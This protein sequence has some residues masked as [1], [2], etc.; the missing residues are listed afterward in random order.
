MLHK[1]M[2]RERDLILNSLMKIHSKS[3]VI[4]TFKSS[5]C[6]TGTEK[7]HALL[8]SCNNI[9]QITDSLHKRTRGWCGFDL[10]SEEFPTFVT[11]VT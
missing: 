4:N 1:N 8:L 6:S 11:M 10:K 7:S 3:T 2:S 5:P 9:M